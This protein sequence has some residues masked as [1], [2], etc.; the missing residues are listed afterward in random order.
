MSARS[1][2][3]FIRLLIVLCKD[4]NTILLEHVWTPSTDSIGDYQKMAAEAQ[5]SKL[6]LKRVLQEER[7][8][9]FAEVV[10]GSSVVSSI[11]H[12]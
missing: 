12:L 3:S 6:S 5:A 8:K 11:G 10:V 4:N 7:V 1:F 2:V 9:G